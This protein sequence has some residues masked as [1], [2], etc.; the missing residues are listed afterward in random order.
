MGF[1]ALYIDVEQPLSGK[2]KTPGSL[3]KLSRTPGDINF[4][5][6]RLGENNLE[7]YSGM[8]GFTEQEVSQLA[9]DGVI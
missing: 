3:F 1:F 2:V 7:V 5:A 9:S 8:L 4:P 6:P